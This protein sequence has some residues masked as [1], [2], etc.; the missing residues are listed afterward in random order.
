[1]LVCVWGYL[2]LSLTRVV[3]CMWVDFS[4][5]LF[6]IY[7]GYALCCSWGYWSCTYFLLFFVLVFISLFTWHFVLLA[8]T[9]VRLWVGV[10]CCGFWLLMFY[11]CFVIE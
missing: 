2:V 8:L 3:W 10:S 6:V 7:C 5:G 1:M 11:V 4:F 9:F